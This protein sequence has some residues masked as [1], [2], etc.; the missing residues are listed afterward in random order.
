MSSEDKSCSRERKPSNFTALTASPM[1]LKSITPLPI[2]TYWRIR[3]DVAQ[4]KIH[5]LLV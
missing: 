5:E 1:A 4:A 3:V 2:G